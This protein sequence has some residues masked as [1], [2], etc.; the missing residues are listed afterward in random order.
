[1]TYHKQQETPRRQIQ[2][3]FLVQL[4]SKIDLYLCHF[5]NTLPKTI[6]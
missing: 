3:L 4:S 5:V 1:M 6:L 2:T